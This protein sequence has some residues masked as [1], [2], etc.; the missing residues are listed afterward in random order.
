MRMTQQNARILFTVSAVSTFQRSVYGPEQRK[1]CGVNVCGSVL[2]LVIRGLGRG[3]G[4]CIE[5]YTF[6]I[7]DYDSFIQSLL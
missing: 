3:S 6:N 4:H 5:P 7:E 1:G 2:H